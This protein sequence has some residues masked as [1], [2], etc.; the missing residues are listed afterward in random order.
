MVMHCWGDEWPW[1]DELYK[2]EKYFCDFFEKCT[3]KRPCTKEKYGTIRYEVTWNWIENEEHCRIYKEAIR[4]TITKF[5][6]VAGEVCMDAGILRDEYFEGWCAGVV[7]QS[8]KSFWSST[9]R[10]KGV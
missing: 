7:Y 9:K 5:P 1:W 4:R 10:P 3:G 2:A 6:K 8:T